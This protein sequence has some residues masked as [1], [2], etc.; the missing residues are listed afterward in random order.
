MDPKEEDWLKTCKTEETSR[1][2]QPTTSGD[3]FPYSLMCSWKFTLEGV[4]QR[5]SG[6]VDT[7]C[8]WKK[9]YLTQWVGGLNESQDTELF[10]PSPLPM[11]ISQDLDFQVC[12]TVL[13]FR[14]SSSTC[15]Y[16]T[17]W[18][19]EYL[20]S[21]RGQRRPAEFQSTILWGSYSASK[22]KL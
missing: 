15:S 4:I 16:Y 17:K 19:G 7:G 22:S 1:S 14:R 18:L 21:L 3:I 12:S 20:E 8:S 6:L 5:S 11:L 2:P 10:T 9:G 13:G